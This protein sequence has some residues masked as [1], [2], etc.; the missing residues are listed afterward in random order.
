MMAATVSGCRLPLAPAS[1][2]AGA[3]AYTV[4]AEAASSAVPRT[5]DLSRLVGIGDSLSA[6]YFNA[7]LDGV[8]PSITGYAAIANE[9]IRAM[10]N[11]FSAG[12]PPVSLAKVMRTDPLLLPNRKRPASSLGAI[13]ART[14][15][16][17]LATSIP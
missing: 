15:A 14:V 5:I 12:I 1:A 16:A 9:F 8:Q 4:S 2:A 3:P 11:R 10:N 7:S 13:D 17:L 6:G